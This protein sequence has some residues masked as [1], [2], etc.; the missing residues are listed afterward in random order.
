MSN[1][2]VD[3]YTFLYIKTIHFFQDF[4]ESWY[5]LGVIE[6]SLM[7]QNLLVEE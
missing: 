7:K 6:R 1:T 5:I 3:L 4:C 2:K